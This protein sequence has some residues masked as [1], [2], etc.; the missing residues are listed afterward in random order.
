MSSLVI[1]IPVN[2]IC[3][4]PYTIVLQL[5]WSSIFRSQGWFHSHPGR[6]IADSEP[7]Q[8]L[9]HR[10]LLKLA[11]FSHLQLCTF[12]K[13]LGQAALTNPVISTVRQLVGLPGSPS[14]TALIAVAMRNSRGPCCCSCCNP[15]GQ[16]LRFPASGL[17]N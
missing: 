13:V 8:D 11:C 7:S 10:S 16:T 2:M 17:F 9:G 15:W 12:H 1:N 5:R 3:L 6:S 14:F 4:I